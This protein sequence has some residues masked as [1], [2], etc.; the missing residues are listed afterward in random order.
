M[1]IGRIVLYCI[2]PGIERPAIVTSVISMQIVSLH[3]FCETDDPLLESFQPEVCMWEPSRPDENP[4][5]G[6]WRWPVRE[7]V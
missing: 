5:P 6:T 4:A 1:T 3:V 2:A 7:S